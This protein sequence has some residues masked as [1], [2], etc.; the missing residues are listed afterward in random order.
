ML[1][2]VSDKPYV[3]V[4]PY[5]GTFVATLLRLGLNRKLRS[6][7]VT[8]V[9]VREV[10]RLKASIDA[11]HG[12]V[13]APNHC[14]DEDAFTVQKLAQ[15]A[16][17]H[18]HIM[19]SAHL[20]QQSKFKSFL[21]QRAGAFSVYR[22]GIDRAAVNSAIEILET[23]VRPL[24]IFPE[25][26]IARTNDKLNELMEGTAMIARSAAKK[27]AKLEPAKKVVVHP[28]AQR[29][30]FHGDIQ[31]TAG[32]VLDEIESRLSWRPQRNKS[33]EQRIIDVGTA[34]LGLKEIE[35]TGSAKQGTITDRLQNLINAILNPLEDQWC[36][37]AHDGTVNARVKR[38]RSAILPDIV[39]GE[40]PEDDR[41]RRWRNL[42]DVYLAMQLSHYPTDYVTPGCKAERVLETIERFELGLT[43]KIRVH[44]DMTCDITVGQPIEVSPAREARGQTDPL[45]VGI[46]SQ[47]K[48]MLGIE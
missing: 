27:R 21:L 10:G 24:V 6:F 35:Y 44:G 42:E 16:G 5:S 20:F 15:A 40:L 25:G 2:V 47:L 17:C 28:V 1:T 38:L 41:A 30:R 33:I 4:P 9:N 26:F 23:N 37:G 32:T 31:K 14:R 19:A 22:E 29:Y 45:L 11:G 34:L 43:D 39:A 8:Q 12:I 48:Q 46:E 18:F 7:G 13:L 3:P 36:A